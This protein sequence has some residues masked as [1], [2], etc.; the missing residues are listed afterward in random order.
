MS[1]KPFDSLPFV[2]LPHREGEVR[3]ALMLTAL[4]S[5]AVLLTACD[6]QVSTELLPKTPETTRA[7]LHAQLEEFVAA[8]EE[9]VAI[10]SENSIPDDPGLTIGGLYAAME[11]ASQSV[12]VHI[13][14]I[15]K[16][17]QALQDLVLEA[18][19][20]G[21]D[22]NVTESTTSTFFTNIDI[23]LESQRYQADPAICREAI[24]NASDGDPL[25]RWGTEFAQCMVEY[26]SRPQVQ[27]G[28]NAADAVNRAIPDL[29][30]AWSDT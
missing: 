22:I 15:E 13:D 25:Q 14:N 10:Y 21:V 27:D 30:R 7:E 1:L 6:V 18:H 24:P 2:N 20:S 12:L 4:A 16:E 29:D 26:F 11:E 19:S 3:K 17:A 9:F 28:L 23:W 5:I 8:V